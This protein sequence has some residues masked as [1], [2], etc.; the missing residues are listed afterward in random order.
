[1]KNFTVENDPTI[2]YTQCKQGIHVECDM[3]YTS[4]GWF[5]GHDA[6]THQI[7]IETFLK[8]TRN[9]LIHAK[10]GKTFSRLI[11]CCKEHGYD[12]EI[13]YHTTEDYVLTTRGNIIV[14]PGKYIIQNSICMMPENMNRDIT[15]DEYNNIVG[16][17]SDKL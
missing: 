3:W 1:M 5:L 4:T 10:D 12:N 8:S 6:P 7:D 11:R 9:A 15:N 2:L 17:C 14:Y 13:F 16:I